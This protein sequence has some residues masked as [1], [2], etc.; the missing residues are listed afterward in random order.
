MKKIN[1][2]IRHIF[3]GYIFLFS[4]VEWAMDGKLIPTLI[5]IHSCST[6]DAYDVSRIA[7]INQNWNKVIHDTVMYRMD[8]IMHWMQRFTGVPLTKEQVTWDQYATVCAGIN[9]CPRSYY[10]GN[11]KCP[12]FF[13]AQLGK[14][15][16]FSNE[17]I[18]LIHSYAYLNEHD[19]AV[20]TIEI[21]LPS[22]KR[23]GFILQFKP[24]VAYFHSQSGWMPASIYMESDIFFRPLI[25]RKGDAVMYLL[26][27]TDDPSKNKRLF[28]YVLTRKGTFRKYIHNLNFN[29]KK[30]SDL[31][32]SLL[33]HI[34]NI[35][36]CVL[37]EETSNKMVICNEA[38][39]HIFNDTLKI[40]NDITANKA[41][42]I[43]F[44][45]IDF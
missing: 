45:E 32:Y 30:I 36:I 23:I 22:K 7:R 6:L 28:E 35:P 21:Q 41:S 16:F 11:I 9:E 24:E 25:T 43:I 42:K 1:V 13:Y 12:Q 19:Q 37:S 14:G 3:Y 15:K 4:N 40:I 34:P 31:L 8:F 5:M 2:T 38:V 17:F 33:P 39:S 29:Q 10:S 27:K 26:E 18:P 44:G 20:R